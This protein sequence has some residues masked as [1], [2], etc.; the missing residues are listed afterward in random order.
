MNTAVITYVKDVTETET[1]SSLQMRCQDGSAL[2]SGGEVCSTIQTFSADLLLVRFINI[3]ISFFRYAY[4]EV[5]I[6]GNAKRID[7]FHQ[8]DRSFS[9]LFRT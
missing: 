6:T 8:A 7:M 5:Q 3:V 9:V 1:K 4:H 2:F